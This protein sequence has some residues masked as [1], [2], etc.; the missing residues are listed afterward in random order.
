MPVLQGFTLLLLAQVA[1]V[2]LAELLAPV[3]RL[4]GPVLGLLLMLALLAWP[5][6][7]RWCSA[8]VG[9]AAEVLLAHLS[10]LFVPIG[11]GVVAHLGLLGRH[12]L[13]LAVV[14]VLSS[15]VALATTAWVL[16]RLWAD[17]TALPSDEVSP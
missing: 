8:A 16:N 12:A 9:A 17:E 7:A 10:L 5:P 6:F 14:L 4:P 3:L 13:A 11:V 1:G 2:G 15:W